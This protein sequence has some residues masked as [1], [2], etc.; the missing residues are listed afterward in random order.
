MTIMKISQYIRQCLSE[1]LSY[2]KPHMGVKCVKNN[3]S[4]E[5]ESKTTYVY[6]KKNKHDIF[7]LIA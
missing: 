4:V 2:S 6:C 1:S 3:K 5:A 7:F